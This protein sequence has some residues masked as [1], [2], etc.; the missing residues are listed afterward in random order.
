MSRIVESPHPPPRSGHVARFEWRA[1][2]GPWRWLILG[3]LGAVPSACGGRSSGSDTDDGAAGLLGQPDDGPTSAGGRETRP[4]VAASGGTAVGAAGTASGGEPAMQPGDVSTDCVLESTLG[5]GWERCTNGMVHRARA[6]TCSSSL[7][8]ADHSLAQ[9]LGIPQVADAGVPYPCVRDSDC[10]QG[11]HGHCELA[12]SGSQCIYGCVTDAECDAGQVCLCG[13]AIGECVRAQCSTDADCGS[14]SLCGDYQ[15]EPQCG[16][17]R[18]AC[19]TPEDLCAGDR[20]CGEGGFC[21]RAVDHS[22]E[23]PVEASFRS[24]AT[25]F[26]SIGR[27]F[28]VDGVERL[29]PSVVRGDWYSGSSLEA[30][31]AESA[32]KNAVIAQGWR[33]QALMEHASVAAFARFSLQLLQLGAP[34]E[35][36]AAAAVAMQDEIRHARACFE[37]A[38]RHSSEDVGPGPL[39]LDGALEQK[40]LTEMALDTLREGC[41][42]ETVAA[43][44][45][46]EALQHCEDPAARAVLQRIA[47]EEGQ[48]AELAWRFVAWA[49]ETRPGLLDRVREAFTHELASAH[50]ARERSLRAVAA[51]DRE[52]AR[53]GLLSPALRAALRQRVLAGV[54]A[55]C[56]EALF[57]GAGWKQPD[58]AIAASHLV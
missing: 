4:A 13:P 42:G 21:T 7:P 35:L 20:D 1:S 53:H 54:V 23:A 44:E 41:I 6:G 33:E 58:P 24:C 43:L 57:A 26:C 9:I 16:G 5:G 39:A 38:R 15:S 19:Q 27:P 29:A 34:A 46:A 28:L 22:S 50:P 51:A 8:R 11:E 55:P 52:L 37:L 56:A 3:A 48:H 14:S 17:T 45:A 30:S 36:V 31:P 25:V 47:V 32:A 18:F 2:L 12:Q 10:T 40:G 49:I